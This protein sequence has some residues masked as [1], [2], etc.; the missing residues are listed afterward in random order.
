MWQHTTVAKLQHTLDSNDQRSVPI[1]DT[2]NL[3]YMAIKIPTEAG[4]Y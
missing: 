3:R 4:D 1:G 2:W